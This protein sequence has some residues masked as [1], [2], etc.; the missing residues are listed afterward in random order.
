MNSNFSKIG[1]LQLDLAL[2]FSYA[3]WIIIFVMLVIITQAY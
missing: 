2:S 1:F 3:A